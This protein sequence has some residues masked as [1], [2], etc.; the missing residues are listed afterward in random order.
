MIL[1]GIEPDICTYSTLVKCLCDNKELESAFS[2]LDRMSTKGIAP[3][4]VIFNNLLAG[5]VQCSNLVLGE[6]LLQDM[7]MLQIKP[8]VTSMS[9][10]VKL[11]SK[12]QALPQALELLQNMKA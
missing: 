6:K 3:D 9:I 12:C 11:Y 4:E 5:C 8:T 2:M 10:L 7:M 1:Q